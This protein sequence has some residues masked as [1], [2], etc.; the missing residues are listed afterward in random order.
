VEIKVEIIGLQGVEDA[1]A[2]AGPKLAKVALRKALRA[3][4]NV[5]LNVAKT[6]APVMAIASPNRQPGELRAAI[7]M[8]VKLSPKQEAGT[9]RI[10]L[11]RDKA[12]GKQSPGVWGL[13]VEFGSVHGAA[14]PYMRPAYDSS[15]AAAQEAFS[16]EIR[17]GVDAL[18]TRS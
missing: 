11:K 18:G 1:L 14:Q 8:T 2:G 6:R 10:G 5:M 9:A 12:K 7:D 4:G 15:H 13:F 17:A 3:G 16:A